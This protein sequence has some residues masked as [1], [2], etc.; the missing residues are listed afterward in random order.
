MVEKPGFSPSV[1]AHFHLLVVFTNVGSFFFPQ[2]PLILILHK[3]PVIGP[4]H[5]KK[6]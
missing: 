2:K 1:C 5:E 3:L 4:I 6:I